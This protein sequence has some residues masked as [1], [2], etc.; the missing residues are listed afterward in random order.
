MLGIGIGYLFGWLLNL[1]KDFA[2]LVFMA[3]GCGLGAAYLF[4][5]LFQSFRTK[6]AI[7]AAK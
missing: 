6:E 4:L 7:G 3:A 5:S 2:I 1:D